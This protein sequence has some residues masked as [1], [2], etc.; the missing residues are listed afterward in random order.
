MNGLDQ[1]VILASTNLNYVTNLNLSGSYS[2]VVTDNL[3]CSDTAVTLL[4]MNHHP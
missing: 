4:K 2:V 1:M 3:G